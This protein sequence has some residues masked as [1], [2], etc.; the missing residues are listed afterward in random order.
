MSRRA[1]EFAR[2]V[3]LTRLGAGPFRQHI[4][5]DAAE[6]EALARRFDLVSL[7]RLEAEIEL[8]RESGG[9]ILLTA[10]FSA[11]FAQ[12]CIA[13]LDPVAG[14]LNERFQLRYGPPEAEATAPAGDDDP[15]FEPLTGEAIDVGEAVAQEFSLA[16]P[17]FPRIPGAAAEDA[18]A[19][20]AAAEGPFAALARLA[21]RERQ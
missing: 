6:R 3:P 21:R 4:A 7:D 20:E 5:A 19:P 17:P 16:L 1:S 2:P 9:T 12:S 15:A 8:S 13:T 18:A 14:S 11:A 10:S